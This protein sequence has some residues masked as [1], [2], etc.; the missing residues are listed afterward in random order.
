M[1]RLVKYGFIFLLVLCGILIA[2]MAFL[3]FT[4]LDP[5]REPIAAM[6]TRAIGRPLELNG[7][8]DINLF[9]RIELVLNDVRLANAAWG[10]EPEMVRVGHAEATI[11][12][13]A[14]LSDPITIRRIR[15][16]DVTVL[17]EQNRQRVGNWA[18]GAPGPPTGKE[19]GDSGRETE[20]R[21]DLPLMVDHVECSNITV[22][23]R[24]PETADQVFHLAALRIQPDP[25]DNV[26]LKSSGALL[27][28][29]MALDAEITSNASLKA[30]GAVN[31]DIQASLGDARLTGQA[32]TSRLATLAGLQGKFHIAVDN[33]QKVLQAAKIDTPLSGPL[34]ADVTVEIDGGGYTATC[35]SRVEGITANID[36]TVIGKEVVLAATVG[37]LDRAGEWFDLKGI[38]ADTLKVNAKADRSAGSAMEIEELHAHVGDNRLAVKGRIDLT[39]ESKVSLT[40][41]SPDLHTLYDALPPIDLNAKATVHRSAAKIDVPE[42]N[43]TFEKSDIRGKL[44]LTTVEK[45]KIAGEISSSLLDLRPFTQKREPSTGSTEIPPAAPPQTQ[46]RYVF[47]KTPLHLEPFQNFEADVKLAVKTIQ[48]DQ[49][50]LKDAVVDAAVHHGNIDAKIKFSGADHGHAAAK[51]NL[52]T[53]GPSATLDT[54]V[55]LSDVHLS[56]LAAEGIERKEV[57]PISVSLELQAA[58]ASPRELAS[59]ANGR[60]LLTQGPGKVNNTVVR[61]FTSDVVDQ[62]FNALNPFAQREAF[63]LLD[64]TVVNVA[65]AEGLAEIATILLQGEKVMVVGNGDIDLKTE[66]LNVEFLTKPRTGVGITADMF[67]KPFIKLTGT[68][69]KPSMGLNKKG[70]LLTGGAAIATGGLSIL[71]KGAFD[72]T[73]GAMDNCERTLEEAGPHIKYDF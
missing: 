44:A 10:T 26:I 29:P 67:V 43:I 50:V 12:F 32:T 55:S 2:G 24:S 52:K 22:T 41:V 37:P 18:M 62:L 71:I 51:L 39:G 25:S 59:T 6:A 73:T 72:R 66:T 48:Y 56:V 3:G 54:V 42:L 17:L 7:Q 27:G 31:L 68:L 33:I 69:A 47:K 8:I 5:Y 21:V 49:G 20:K 35:E 60:V 45:P 64:C 57:P 61:T 40:L 34:T 46:D 13:P 36:G 53:Q 28:Y 58:G 30:H 16:N 11:G 9:P 65:M 70:T 38:R 19:E 14:L 23:L 63:T 4:D 1:R 15:L